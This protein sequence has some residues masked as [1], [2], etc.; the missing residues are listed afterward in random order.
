[1]FAGLLEIIADGLSVLSPVLLGLLVSFVAE[2]QQAS[3]PPLY[4]GYLYAGLIFLSAI[5]QTLF[6][7]THFK[8][9]CTSVTFLSR[10]QLSVLRVKNQ[11]CLFVSFD[12]PIL[13][14]SYAQ[15]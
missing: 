12:Q 13:V 5:G 1:M 6:Q 15:L 10:H 4:V 11:F 9:T 14:F 7:N 3:P 2:S 8:I